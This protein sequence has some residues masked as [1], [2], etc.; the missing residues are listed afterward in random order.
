MSGNIVNILMPSEDQLK[1]LIEHYKKG[2]F[3]EAEKLAISLTQ[4][5]PKHQF[6]WK[7]L[8][9]SF[10]QTG[11]LSESL[12]TNQKSVQL[13]PKDAEAHYNLGNTLYELGRLDDAEAS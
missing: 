2:R 3:S 5:F 11:R 13:S 12:I 1:R 4:Q 10:K 7:V 9:A 6:A 8:G